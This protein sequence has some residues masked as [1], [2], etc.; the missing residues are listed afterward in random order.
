MSFDEILDLTA[1]VFSF[2][3]I[4]TSK[5]RALQAALGVCFLVSR[6][7]FMITYACYVYPW[8]TL[9]LR[10]CQIFYDPAVHHGMNF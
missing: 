9:Y 3:I 10:S 4:S 6:S 7:F 5:N 1:D 8:D 2:S